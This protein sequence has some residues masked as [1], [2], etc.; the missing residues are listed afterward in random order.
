VAES[1]IWVFG[2]DVLQVV[3]R[4]IITADFHIVVLDEIYADLHLIGVGFELDRIDARCA[5][6]RFRR[7]K[8]LRLGVFDVAVFDQMSEP[9]AEIGM[10]R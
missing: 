4:H 7:H 9:A 5:D 3:H 2:H 1:V 6:D 10:A 8:I